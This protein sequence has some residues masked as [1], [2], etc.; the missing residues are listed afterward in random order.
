MREIVPGIHTWSTYSEE[1]AM[2]FNGY[3][4]ATGAGSLLVDPVAPGEEGWAALDALAPYDG[5]QVTN[6]NHG[7]DADAF[8]ARY[9]APVRIG[10]DDRARAAID[11][12]ETLRGGETLA[13]EVRAIAAPGKS[14][15]ELAFFIPARRALVVGDVVIGVPAGELSTYPPEKIDDRAELLRSAARLAELDFDALLLCDGAPLPV[16]GRATL[17]AF[18]AAQSA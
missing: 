15:G 3:A 8:R 13:G 12:D 14:P 10:A 1:R 2:T 4:I 5:V 9:G 17:R 18:V 11:A 6:R 7:R 16:G